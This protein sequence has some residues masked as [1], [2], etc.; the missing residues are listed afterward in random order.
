M[1]KKVAVTF[2]Y[3]LRSLHQSTKA[4]FIKEAQSGSSAFVLFLYALTKNPY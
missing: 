4:D 3:T 2:V 1:L